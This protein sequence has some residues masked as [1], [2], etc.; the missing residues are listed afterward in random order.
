MSAAQNIGLTIGE[1]LSVGGFDDIPLAE[2]AHPPLTTVRQ[3]VYEI[4]Q[5]ITRILV[6]LIQGTGAAGTQELLIPQLMIRG[7]SGPPPD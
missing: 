7:S 3:P 6:E 4:G 1:D 5:R 2:H